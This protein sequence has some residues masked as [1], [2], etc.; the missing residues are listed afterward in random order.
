MGQPKAFTDKYLAA[1][2]PAPGRYDVLDGARRGL[3][4]RVFPTG[5]KTFVF[6]FQRNGAVA[7]I[8]LGNYPAMPLRLAYEAHAELTKRL[9]RGDDPRATPRGAAAPGASSDSDDSSPPTGPTVGELAAEFLR[10]Y[11]QRERKR[12]EEAEKTI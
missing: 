1:L 3:T 9:N 4:L 5:T 8:T 11:V 10:R 2:K 12:P 6:R 7:R